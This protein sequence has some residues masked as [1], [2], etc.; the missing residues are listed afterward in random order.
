MNYV[1]LEPSVGALFVTEPIFSSYSSFLFTSQ[2]IFT[3]FFVLIIVTATIKLSKVGAKQ[4]FLQ[5][6]GQYNGKKVS[7]QDERDNAQEEIFRDFMRPVLC[8]VMVLFLFFVLSTINY[9]V[10]HL[11]L[12]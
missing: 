3:I 7:T 8:I 1:A 6:Y 4:Y 10:L 11:T 12:S 2:F 9:N 5:V